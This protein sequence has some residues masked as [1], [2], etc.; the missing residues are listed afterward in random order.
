MDFQGFSEFSENHDFCRKLKVVKSVPNRFYAIQDMHTCRE[1]LPAHAMGSLEPNGNRFGD[2]YFSTK[3]VIFR[4][5]LGILE[6]PWF[7]LIFS[8]FW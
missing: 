2:F 1:R 8:Q 5:I 4:K 3:I 6:N 7:S